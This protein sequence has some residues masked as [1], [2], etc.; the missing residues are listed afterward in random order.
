MAQWSDCSSGGHEFKFQQPPVMRN[1][2]P[3]ARNEWG[4]IKREKGRGGA[5]RIKN[6]YFRVGEMVQWLR[7]LSALPEVLS[8]NP[9]NHMVAPNHL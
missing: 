2:Q 6:A 1:K 7:A 5:G 3:L 8:S 9:T 4:R